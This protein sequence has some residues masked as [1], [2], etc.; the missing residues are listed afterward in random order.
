MSEQESKV[1]R[2]ILALSIESAA[3]TSRLRECKPGDIVTYAE[4]SLLLGK[5]AREH[6]GPLQAARHRL[7]RDERMIFEVI[8]LVGVKCLSAPEAAASMASHVRRVRKAARKGVRKA[9]AIDILQ[10][11]PEARAGLVATASFLALVDS[12]GA[13]ASMRRLEAS[14]EKQPTTQFL[15][16]QRAL[17]ALREA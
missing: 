2:I 8:R 7:E 3:L 5:N 4:L 15:P 6:R 10:V 11:P 1:V 12:A 16:L 14:V 9:Q 13:P 17:A